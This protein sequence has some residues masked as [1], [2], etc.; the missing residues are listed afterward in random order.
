MQV[1]VRIKGWDPWPQFP[2]LNNA[3]LV[4]LEI[5][6]CISV[7]THGQNRLYVK[8]DW[9]THSPMMGRYECMVL[10]YVTTMLQ[11]GFQ[12]LRDNYKSI[13]IY[14]QS[15]TEYYGGKVL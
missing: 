14:G 15:K 1:V 8:A 3:L 5:P 11:D 2:N 7:V 9:A 12:F 13:H 4:T 6:L 10:Q